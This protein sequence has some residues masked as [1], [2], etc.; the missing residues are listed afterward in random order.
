MGFVNHM[1]S[2]PHVPLGAFRPKDVENLKGVS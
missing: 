1:G 2:W